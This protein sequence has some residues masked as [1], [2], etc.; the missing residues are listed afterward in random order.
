MLFKIS[1]SQ[2]KTLSILGEIDNICRELP[3]KQNR[4]VGNM[5]IIF[6]SFQ[7]NVFLGKAK[8][9]Q[10]LYVSFCFLNNKVLIF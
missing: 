7:G 6:G 8:P 4:L 3:L 9:Q 10:A 5:K 2:T 1:D